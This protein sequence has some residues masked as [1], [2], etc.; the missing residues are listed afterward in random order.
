MIS[1]YA[2]GRLDDVMMRLVDFLYAFPFLV[3]VILMQ[4]YFKALAR[5]SGTEGIGGFLI[6]LNN[7][8][9]GMLFLFIAIGLLNWLGMARI[10]RGQVLLEDFRHTTLDPA[11]I[12]KVAR[13]EA[14]GVWERFR[15]L[16]KS[17][18][19]VLPL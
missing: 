7:D 12:A 5:R 18:D 3:V 16:A 11:A 13:I 14:F 19:S 2:G 4:T 10:A 15:E 1:G 8:L 6:G 17:A 9:G